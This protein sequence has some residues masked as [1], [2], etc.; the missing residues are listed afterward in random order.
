[1]SLGEVVHEVR[2]R[3]IRTGIEG[4]TQLRKYALMR[5]LSDSLMALG[6]FAVKASGEIPVYLRLAPLFIQVSLFSVAVYVYLLK[7]LKRLEVYNSSRYRSAGKLVRIGLGLGVPLFWFYA[8]I[9]A[10]GTAYSVGALFALG[11]LG[12]IATWIA[13]VIG[14]LGLALLMFK[15]YAEFEYPI[16]LVAAVLQLLTVLGFVEPL[17]IG[18]VLT[19]IILY[20]ALGPVINSLREKLGEYM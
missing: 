1:L 19:N 10:V 17:V 8:L 18:G 3:I 11:V 9:T 20:I 2:S 15:I 6:A 4:F 12:L 16:L 5:A 13:T 14:A 7:A